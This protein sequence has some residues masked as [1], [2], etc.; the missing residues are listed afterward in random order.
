MNTSLGIVLVDQRLV[1]IYV[2]FNECQR[3]AY[4]NILIL[5]VVVVWRLWVELK[6]SV[7][8]TKHKLR[9]AQIPCH[10]YTKLISGALKDFRGIEVNVPRPM[11]LNASEHRKDKQK[12]I[13]FSKIFIQVIVYSLH[14]CWESHHVKASLTERDDLSYGLLL[15]IALH[16]LIEIFLVWLIR[17]SKAW[18]AEG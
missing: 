2:F 8:Y 18:S 3:N 15:D 5:G 12:K 17:G 14:V 1:N 10:A 7:F 16:N 11:L 13:L 9:H 6:A 4:L